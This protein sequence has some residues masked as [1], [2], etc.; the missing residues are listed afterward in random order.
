MARVFFWTSTAFWL[1]MMA[2]LFRSDILPSY[3]VGDSTGYRAVIGDAEAPVVREMAVYDKEGQEVGVSQTAITPSPDGTYAISNVTSIE[4]RLGMVLSRV[5]ALLDVRLDSRKELTN[6]TLD[7]NALGARASATGVREGDKL[8][9]KA[10]LNGQPFEQELPYENG[11]ISSYFE[12]FSLG[13]R[14][15]VGQVWHT[16]ILD[17]LS[18]KFTTAEIRVVGRETIELSLRKGEPKQPIDTYKVVMDWGTTRI[19][20]W[21]TDKGVVLKEETPLGYTLVYREMTP[22][23]TPAGDIEVLRR[24]MRRPES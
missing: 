2:L 14:L 24:E 15:K 4:L 17:P 16:R 13:S 6:L 1:V 23:D 8:K 11:L 20:A 9:L 10:T 19:S 21:A 18:Q 22:D 7:V 3:L 5:T 12:P